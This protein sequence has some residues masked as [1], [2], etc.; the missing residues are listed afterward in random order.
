MSKWVWILVIM[1]GAGCAERGAQKLTICCAGDSLM[2]P[3]PTHLKSLLRARGDEIHIRDWARGGLSS[4]TYMSFYRKHVK[5]QKDYA[6]DFILL[7]LG[8]NDVR[9]LLSGG[10]NLTRFASNMKAIIEEFKSFSPHRQNNVKILLASIPP[11][12]SSEFPEANQ[13]I[14][15]DLNPAIKKISELEEV[16]FVDNWKVLSSRPHLYRPDGVHP[17]PTGERVLAQN[18]MIAVRRLIRTSTF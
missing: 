17:S 2:R 18:W 6:A 1:L 15:T 3:I 16:Y 4:Q 9:S 14:E 13:F 10:Y 7:Q 5:K 12:Y 8:T 11:L